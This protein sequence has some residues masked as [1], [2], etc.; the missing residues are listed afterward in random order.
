MNEKECYKKPW[1]EYRSD[2][3]RA[4]QTIRS[5]FGNNPWHEHQKIVGYLEGYVAGMRFA[6]QQIVDSEIKSVEQEAR[7]K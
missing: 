2:A 5:I 3:E 4:L 1:Y 7:C 6:E